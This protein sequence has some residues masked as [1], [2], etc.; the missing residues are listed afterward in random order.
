MNLDNSIC[1]N[2]GKPK[3][4]HYEVPVLETE[5]PFWECEIV[6]N[7]GVNYRF[8]KEKRR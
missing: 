1:A 4:R 2:C 3:W 5:K 6:R 7:S 8:K